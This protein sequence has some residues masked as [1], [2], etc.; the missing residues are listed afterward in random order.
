MALYR[1]HQ[2]EAQCC[3]HVEASMK[4]VARPSEP[5]SVASSTLCSA[6]D[7]DQSRTVT[8]DAAVSIPAQNLL[9]VLGQVSLAKFRALGAI[10]AALYMK[11][12]AACIVESAAITKGIESERSIQ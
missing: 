9:G 12:A 3:A 1:K 11:H 2:A 5:I 6:T 10:S 7:V 8:V 4:M